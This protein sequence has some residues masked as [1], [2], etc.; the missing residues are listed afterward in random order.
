MR[1]VGAVAHLDPMVE[2]AM[3]SARCERRRPAN[4]LFLDEASFPPGGI[5]EGSEAVAE[6]GNQSL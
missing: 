5:D 6:L 3:V 4:A 1:S 2:A